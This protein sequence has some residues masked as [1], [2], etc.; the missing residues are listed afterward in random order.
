MLCHDIG[1]PGLVR[2]WHDNTGRHPDWRL[3]GLEMRK[4]GAAEWTHF[5]CGRCAGQVQQQRSGLQ[6]SPCLRLSTA[7]HNLINIR[8]HK[9]PRWL[10][11]EQDDGR[12]CR[13]LAAAGTPPAS[14]SVAYR[15]VT[16]TSD[17]RGAGTDANPHVT[18]HGTACDGT[19]HTLRG[20]AHNFEM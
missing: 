10:S 6:P 13:E 1:T 15:V 3:L 16:I 4:K 9:N 17:I 20:G 14:A 19:R 8:T 11:T 5:P 18:L 2:V 12:I 7:A